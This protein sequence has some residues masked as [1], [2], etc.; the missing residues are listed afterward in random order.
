M[1]STFDGAEIN[2]KQFP[3]ARITIAHQPKCIKKFSPTIVST[4]RERCFPQ[5]NNLRMW[6]RVRAVAFEKDWKWKLGIIPKELRCSEIGLKE[7]GEIQARF[8]DYL[9]EMVKGH[10]EPLLSA[11]NIKTVS[12]QVK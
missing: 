2:G 12:D 1:T 9:Q 10:D 6:K 11:I 5:T 4:L 7:A 3:F 8:F